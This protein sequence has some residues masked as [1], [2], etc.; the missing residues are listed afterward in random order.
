MNTLSSSTGFDGL[1]NYAAYAA[2]AATGVSCVALLALHAL[3]T[4]FAPSWRMVSEYANGRV[5]ML[6]TIVFLTWALS[7]FALAIALR[8][9]SASTGGMI[10]LVCL[11]LA[12]IGQ[13]M[14]GLFDINHR[15]HGPA[16]MI[17]IPALCAAAVLL[18][19]AM[20]RHGN[21]VAPPMWTAHLPWLS[22]ALM[23][24]AF[25]AFAS[26]LKAAGVDLSA[27]SGPLQELPAGVT[28][29][30]GFA[31]RMLFAASYLW[32]ALAALAVLK[33]AP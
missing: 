14:G 33:A 15:L 6:L 3:D 1:A 25:A 19:L 17:G 21:L 18:N 10:G 16:A 30:V 29:Y 26:S 12:G 32:V 8:P 13:A 4:A 11:F 7:S 28:G 27:Q 20:A 22:F 31:N 5:P 2:L 9:L 23:L 24:G